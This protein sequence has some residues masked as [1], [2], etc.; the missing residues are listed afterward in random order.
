MHI[1]HAFDTL[2]LTDDRIEGS[3]SSDIRSRV[4]PSLTIEGAMACRMGK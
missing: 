1:K 2:K 3:E 4:K